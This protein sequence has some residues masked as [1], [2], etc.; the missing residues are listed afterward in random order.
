M[1]FDRLLAVRNWKRWMALY[2]MPLIVCTSMFSQT[3]EHPD[4]ITQ[5]ATAGG[6]MRLAG[7]V[8]PLTKQATDLGE[9]DSGMQLNSLT[10]N[11]NLSAAQQQ[12][13]NTLLAAQQ[14]PKSPL[15]HQWLTQEQY[16]AR[17]GL[18]DADLNT[19]TEWLK[20]QGF[21]VTGISKSRNA[22]R[23]GGK[24]W[25]VESAFHT[26]LHRFQLN[27]ETHFSNT[28]DI[29]V[30][31]GIRTVLLN[32][33]GL[34]NF[35][36]KPNL[37]K[38]TQPDYFFS[39]N[40]YSYNFLTPGDWATIYDV[41]PIY[42]AGFTGTGMHVGVVGQT[43]IY[44]S[45]ITNFRSAAGLSAPNV[46]YVCIYPSIGSPNSSVCTDEQ[47]G[48][49]ISTVGDLGEADLDIEWAG[50]IAK[51]ATV[52]FIY[53]PF[54]ES[55]VNP[56]SCTEEVGDPYT[57][58]GKVYGGGYDVFDALENAVEDYQ[59]AEGYVLP[60]ISMSYSACE[61]DADSAFLNFMSSLGQEASTQG[62]TIVVAAGDTGAFGCDV[63]TDYPA[64][65]GVYAPV[66]ADSP[67][68]TG[69][70][71]TTLSGDYSTPGNYWIESS[72]TTSTAK[73]YIP[74]SVW[75]DTSA[76]YGLAASGGGQS[77][78]FQQPNW[79]NGL[80]SGQTSWRMI[81]DVA[82][83]ASANH[84]G[85]LVCSTG[86]D[87]TK[88]GNYCSSGFLSTG[89]TSGEKIPDVYGGTS[90][91]TPSFA[92]MLTLLVQ[93][94][95]SGLGN[96]N[97]KLYPLATQANYS[98]IF[99]GTETGNYGINGN[100]GSIVPCETGT[101][102]CP[103]SGEFG[104][105]ASANFPYYNMATGLGS[106]DG[107][108]LFKAAVPPTYTL[109]ASSA[110][111]TIQSGSS[112]SVTLN[113]AATNYTGT[114][115][116]ATSI[117]SSD[118]TVSAV[119][120]SAPSVSFASD[121]N[122]STTLTISTTASAANHAPTR[123]WKTTG[124]VIVFAV[125]LGAPV[126]LR[127]KRALAVLLAALAISLAGLMMACGGGS[128]G[129]GSSS[130]SSSG[131]SGTGSGGSSST[132]ARVYSVTVTPTGTGTVSNAAPITIT[133]TVQ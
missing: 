132:S 86:D 88:Y 11:I 10:L 59:T 1:I 111:L 71:G 2:A 29:Q 107:Y 30:P 103:S 78:V 76:Q 53:A 63:G 70:G 17:F 40:G 31:A 95:G 94:T 68:F 73:G 12:D 51:D 3:T 28:T 4:R 105:T 41:T 49:A 55:C 80:V 18:T 19:V 33:R 119:S 131:G 91:A 64:E 120:A 14:N 129:G 93:A 66:P 74:E 9:V 116:F 52:D 124:G 77:T 87:S 24:V 50:G 7:S 61:A 46:K 101:S 104:Y 44:P 13:L 36:P 21:T 25:Q 100:S 123:G 47:P 62:Q 39:L 84:D 56:P 128:S 67:N 72:A 83:A 15:Y 110:A 23:F 133:V 58:Y 99:H 6:I 85:Y 127:R 112:T 34:N 48:G 90:A 5:G 102:G 54:Q 117:T 125:L 121:T 106:I 108:G 60:V 37:R 118:G 98:T 22:I 115:S 57:T 126:T 75:N 20:S 42:N 27:G 16:G 109:S 89:G 32:V 43:Y 130:N 69:V 38:P 113:L 35:R 97:E 122:G 8:H 26:Q 96:I 92:G 82:F 65:D 81:P 114:V 45:D 79:Q